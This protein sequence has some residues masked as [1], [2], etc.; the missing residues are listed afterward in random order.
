MTRKILILVAIVVMLA[1]TGTANSKGRTGGHNNNQDI[2]SNASGQAGSGA[3]DGVQDYSDPNRLTDF[4]MEFRIPATTNGWFSNEEYQAEIGLDDFID[5]RLLITNMDE[6]RRARI[7]V[8]RSSDSFFSREHDRLI[9][10]DFITLKSYEERKVQFY[11]LVPEELGGSGKHF[12]FVDVTYGSYADISSNEILSDFVEVDV[13]DPA[14]DDWFSETEYLVPPIVDP[15]EPVEPEIV[16]VSTV[17]EPVYSAPLVEDTT[18]ESKPSFTGD[19]SVSKQSLPES[20]LNVVIP[21]DVVSKIFEEFDVKKYLSD[22]LPEGHPPVSSWEPGHY[23]FYA[24]K[25]DGGIK[26][27][28]FCIR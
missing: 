14:M 10:T 26:D 18:T 13:I 25:D 12:L 11:H 28:T 24:R 15:A 21:K 4:V 3:K 1:I 2:V 9:A 17:V 23:N 5:I 27:L 22:H 19:C 20:F 6:T 7:D 8:Y 16:E